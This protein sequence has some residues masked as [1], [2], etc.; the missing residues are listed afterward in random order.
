MRWL[1]WHLRK[2]QAG[3]NQEGLWEARCNLDR[4]CQH[5]SALQ[6]WSLGGTEP[7]LI[8]SLLQGASRV[9]F[10]LALSSRLLWRSCV[11]SG[12][13]GE[14]WALAWCRNSPTLGKAA[15]GH[16]AGRPGTKQMSVSVLIRV[17]SAEHGLSLCA[18]QAGP[19][20][21][22]VKLIHQLGTNPL[23]TAA[24]AWWCLGT[25]QPTPL[26]QQHHITL[27]VPEPVP[28]CSQPKFDTVGSCDRAAAFIA[29][30][31]QLSPWFNT[32]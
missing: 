12:A 4:K 31:A 13:V 23:P 30:N 24:G 19:E 26:A 29:V 7:R 14:C 5:L 28:A 22:P 9:G 15:S 10:C 21:V 6:I 27:G 20:L 1:P 17:S 2:A 8:S 16:R 3:E 25:L 11:L 32:L 18:V